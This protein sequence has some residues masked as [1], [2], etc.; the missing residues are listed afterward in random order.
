MREEVA[1]VTEISTDAS[2]G[3]SA[4]AH[5][6]LPDR[7]ACPTAVRGGVPARAGSL[8]SGPAA[9]EGTGMP[10]VGVRTQVQPLH[11][12]PKPIQNP[13]IYKTRAGALG[14]GGLGPHPAREP[15]PV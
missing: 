12:G 9:G 13:Y 8:K 1:P 11:F 10:K 2:R 4:R 14:G 3:V 5:V 7:A 6:K 15:E